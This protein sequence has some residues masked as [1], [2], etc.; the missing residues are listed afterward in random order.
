M[1]NKAIFLQKTPTI[2]LETL[3]K[4]KIKARK[5]P[6]DNFILPEI[7]MSMVKMPNLNPPTQRP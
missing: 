3:V 4:I 5:N 6:T 2:I 1:T 7:N